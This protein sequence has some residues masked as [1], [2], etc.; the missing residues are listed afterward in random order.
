MKYPEHRMSLEAA[1][2]LS[3]SVLT[4]LGHQLE[5]RKIDSVIYTRY[6]ISLLQQDMADI[7]STDRDEFWDIKK[8]SKKAKERRDVKKKPVS[9]EERRKN[10][11]VECLLSVSDEDNDIE[12]LVEE[13]FIRLKE[14]KSSQGCFSPL[15]INT[16]DESK[17]QV[18]EFQDPAER[19]YAAFPALPGDGTPPQLSPSS[20]DNIWRKNR[21][22][23]SLAGETSESKEG[24]PRNV[25]P[26]HAEAFTQEVKTVEKS[27]VDSKSSTNSPSAP[28]RRRRSGRGDSSQK[29]SPSAGGRKKNMKGKKEIEAQ[30]KA[31]R[32]LSW[33]PPGHMKKENGKVDTEKQA[34]PEETE[35]EK[36]CSMVE[37]MLKEMLLSDRKHVQAP[38]DLPMWAYFPAEGFTEGCFTEWFRE[39][40]Q[41]PEFT[42]NDDWYTQPL[43]HIFYTPVSQTKRL[44]KR[45]SYP[46]MLNFGEQFEW[47]TILSLKKTTTDYILLE[48]VFDPNKDVPK[49]DVLE[50][51]LS[52]P[53][54]AVSDVVEQPNEDLQFSGEQEKAINNEGVECLSEEKGKEAKEVAK[55][56]EERIVEE[57]NEAVKETDE[58]PAWYN[59]DLAPTSPN[60]LFPFDEFANFATN[61]DGKSKVDFNTSALPLTLPSLFPG[62]DPDCLVPASDTSSTVSSVEKGYFSD[63]TET[64]FV[65]DMS[66]HSSPFPDML[67]LMNYGEDDDTGQMTTSTASSLKGSRLESLFESSRQDLLES[68]EKSE[69]QQLDY[70]EAKPE[71]DFCADDLFLYGAEE[72]DCILYGTRNMFPNGATS[73]GNPLESSSNT[74]EKQDSETETEEKSTSVSSS[75]L[76]PQ[77]KFTDSTSE[78]ERDESACFPSDLFNSFSSV[79]ES[80]G[81]SVLLAEPGLVE[82]SYVLDLLDSGE[83]SLQ[84]ECSSSYFVH[85]SPLSGS[86]GSCWQSKILLHDYGDTFT[87]GSLERSSELTWDAVLSQKKHIWSSAM[88][89][90]P[91]NLSVRSPTLKGE[92]WQLW[93]VN[94]QKK[95]ADMRAKNTDT[96][97]CTWNSILSL[98]VYAPDKVEEEE[99]WN[100]DDEVFLSEI[101]NEE[102]A[103]LGLQFLEEINGIGKGPR[104]ERSVSESDL[105]SMADNPFLDM[106]KPNLDISY[107]LIPSENSAFQGVVPK[108]LHHV[109]S[110]PNLRY[111]SLVSMVREDDLHPPGLASIESP[112]EHLYF[113]AKT[114]FRPIQTPVATPDE[115]VEFQP[116][117]LFGGMSDNSGTP[118]QQFLSPGEEEESNFRPKFKIQ[119]DLD[120]YIQTGG[121]LDE[122]DIDYERF[123]QQHCEQA[124]NSRTEFIEEIVVGSVLEENL[125]PDVVD[126]SSSYLAVAEPEIA[127]T[128]S[129]K[130]LSLS[131]SVG[132]SVEDESVLQLCTS[133]RDL[134][135]EKKADKSRKITKQSQ[136]VDSKVPDDS[137]WDGQKIKEMHLS[138]VQHYHDI[139]SAGYEMDL[140]PFSVDNETLYL[141]CAVDE[142]LCSSEVTTNDEENKSKEES[143]KTDELYL[144]YLENYPEY[145][146][147]ILSASDVCSGPQSYEVSG[148][149]PIPHQA[150]Y[151]SDL[152]KQWLEKK[153]L[154]G[155]NAKRKSHKLKLRRD[156]IKRCKP[157]SFSWRVIVLRSDC[158][159]SHDLSSITCRFWEEGLCFKGSLCPFYHG[160][161]SDTEMSLTTDGKSGDRC[162]FKKDEVS[163]T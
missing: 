27:P 155:R 70:S 109:R 65:F 161:P 110:A 22:S 54:E 8:D 149:M 84:N 154:S 58:T 120:K 159:F 106:S 160:Y 72:E 113:S 42:E 129:V 100:N 16:K 115:D 122:S 67:L 12:S 55:D 144:Y 83:V 81:G 94:S 158:K 99:E 10:A 135:S 95:M 134:Y 20:D 59:D 60:V 49:E 133:L 15:A 2:P 101:I 151:S 18:K 131:K 85:L 14:T 25:S 143:D 87:F 130:N 45:H 126:Q 90:S 56:Q 50:I 107:E 80:S 23:G 103:V 145:D 4:W 105:Q 57:T 29:M 102:D 46:P 152:E 38:T 96:N 156:S 136:G 124:K 17:F 89:R 73:N 108:Q 74:E 51:L 142:T 11:A 19:Y 92:L 121:S 150:V 47:N 153:A 104:Y 31:V 162:E 37:Q 82:H 128:D 44:Y 26:E 79:G 24:S 146:S 141:P 132:P 112:V 1:M 117:D 77:S 97:A 93:D 91:V 140:H 3:D 6:V 43:E 75:Q 88:S 36:Y 163:R 33:P 48:D 137:K 123:R 157:C 148:L 98:S 118:Y 86:G 21:K 116:K 39:D 64:S 40:S 139:W 125:E 53:Q 68:M 35:E 69:V 127:E 7:D 147:Y 71:F 32:F 13:L 52:H 61:V 5:L 66:R 119:K 63:V 78:D 28:E 114:H 30:S 41:S 62:T 111:K 76:E 34:N 138:D 9:E